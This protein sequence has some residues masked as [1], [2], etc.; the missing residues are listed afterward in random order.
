MALGKLQVV[1]SN[2]TMPCLLIVEV[3]SQL[4]SPSLPTDRNNGHPGILGGNR[5]LFRVVFF[6]PIISLSEHEFSS[7]AGRCSML[8]IHRCELPHTTSAW[9]CRPECCSSGAA[10]GVCGVPPHLDGSSWPTGGRM[11]LMLFP[12]RISLHSSALVFSSMLFSSLA[13]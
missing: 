13:T 11:L 2:Q 4:A 6:V 3:S 7:A 1:C 9:R 12:V 5:L 8:L 10:D